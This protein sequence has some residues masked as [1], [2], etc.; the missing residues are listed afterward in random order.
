MKTW[1]KATIGILLVLILGF[2]IYYFV[3]VEKSPSS[4][5]SSIKEPGERAECIT[6]VALAINDSKLCTSSGLEDVWKNNCIALMA[7]SRK[8]PDACLEIKD[9]QSRAYCTF[10]VATSHNMKSLCNITYSQYW[11]DNCNYNL[12]ITNNDHELCKMVLED[13]R[14][15][16]CHEYI[17]Y[18]LWDYNGC[19]FIK[20]S[21]D[22]DRCL[23][24][25][26]KNTGDLNACNLTT[27]G[28]M[29]DVC[30]QR[31]A[32]KIN[33]TEIC[34]KIGWD[35][36]REDCYDIIKN[37]PKYES[38]VITLNETT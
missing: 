13:G 8:E 10:L 19:T 33:N 7:Q 26:A 17:S 9:N 32:I 4:Q 21:S 20:N 18:A 37:G 38:R 34:G 5:C 1:K 31:I 16:D 25:V 15:D 14:E 27:P 12:S 24:K 30:F 35:Q 22:M 23:L 36:V 3:A 11:S 28:L 6:K 29:T 2:I